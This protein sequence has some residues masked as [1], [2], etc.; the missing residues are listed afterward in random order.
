MNDRIHS[1]ARAALVSAAVLCPWP[2]SAIVT[3]GRDIELEGFVQAQNLLRTPK[4]EDAEA[5]MQRNTAQVEGKYYFLRD[6]VAFNRFDTGP[7]EE[8]TLNVI[9]RAVYDSIYDVRDSYDDA[10][11][12]S[13][14]NRWYEYKFR[15]AFVDFVL[16]PFSLR[17]GKQQVVWGETD[18]F[19]A[20]DIINPLDLTWH[21]SRESWEDIR[22]PLWMARGIYD[23]GKFGFLE[24]S[25]FEAIWIPADFKPNKVST[26]PRRPWAFLGD[27]LPEAANSVVIA[28]QAYDLAF[29]LRDRSPDRKLANGQGGF[30]FKAIW[31]EIDFSLNY[32][33]GFSADPGVK[34]RNQLFNI[35]GTTAHVFGDLVNPRQHTLGL[36]ANYSE[37]RFTQAVFRLETAFTTDVPVAVA[38]GAPAAVDPEGDQYETA[39]R[40]T[41]MVAADRPTWIPWLNKDRTFFLSTQVFWRRWIDYDESFRGPSSVHRAMI[42]GQVLPGRFVSVQDDTIDQNEFV[43]TFSASS[44]YGP[45]GLIKPLFVFAIDPRSTGAYNRFQV[46]YLYTNHIMFRVQQDIYWQI[47]DN[48]VGP[49]GLG[50]IW[51]HDSEQ[52]R[53]E[54]NFTVIFQF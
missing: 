37:E 51:G 39:D 54:T 16:P 27:G 47:H 29:H 8:A 25:F 5:I 41:V 34:M 12:E 44:S 21:W 45:A 11:T 32:F 43:I 3:L 28:N 22:I 33:Y 50:D 52:S 40:T 15:E 10:F 53:H 30:R 2:A 26:D 4:F 7:L 9:G 19:R 49:W 18:N 13:G 36:T 14:K 48:N 35:N 42:G 23:I 31:G 24:E 6:G 38:P 46:E 17:L 20:L 1:L